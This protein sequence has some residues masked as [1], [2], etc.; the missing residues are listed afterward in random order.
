MAMIPQPDAFE[1][2][3]AAYL[4]AHRHP[5][6][7]ALHVAAKAAALLALA[8]A[9]AAESVLALLAVPALMVLPCWL[10][11][12]LFER[13]RPT[14]WSTPDAS[15]LGP[16]IRWTRRHARRETVGTD[17]PAPDASC[18]G[19]RWYSLRADL[20]MCADELRAWRGRARA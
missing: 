12:W 7:R 5:V 3:Y 9:V 11:H 13:N 6:N 17:R 4:A 1:R 16:A 19:S 8:V 2:F 15:I 18:G 10:G 20:R 14:A